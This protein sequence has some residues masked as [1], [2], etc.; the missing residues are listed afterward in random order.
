M[1]LHQ[2]LTDRL[3][4]AVEEQ[5]VLFTLFW[6][7]EANK[8][9][10]MAQV[11]NS[12]HSTRKL[13]ALESIAKN[14]FTKLRKV[15]LEILLLSGADTRQGYILDLAIEAKNREV[16]EIL[17]GWENGDREDLKVPL[18]LLALP[19]ADAGDV[20]DQ[21]L[22]EPP[23][24]ASLT[25]YNPLPDPASFPPAPTAAPPREPTPPTVN[26]VEAPAP[27]PPR[28]R[29]TPPSRTETK[30]PP[31]IPAPSEPTIPRPR[32]PSYPRTTTKSIERERSPSRSTRERRQRPDSPPPRLESTSRSRSKSRSSR[33][34]S[35]R[36]RPPPPILHLNSTNLV[37]INVARFPVGWNG[38]DLQ[39]MFGSIGVAS[40]VILCHST[41][42][43]TYAFL[44]VDRDEANRCIRL[45]E[46]SLQGD[47]R[48]R[49]NF[50][51]RQSQNFSRGPPLG[52][53]GSLSGSG[54]GG[55]GGDLSSRP[56]IPQRPTLSPPPPS[57]S[58]TSH[59]PP[60]YPPRPDSTLPPSPST[61]FTNGDSYRSLPPSSSSST[62]K[63]VMILNLPYHETDEARIV[64]N[65]LRYFDLIRLEE[66]NQAVA[67]FP[68]TTK[69]E[70]LYKLWDDYVVDG[71]RLKVVYAKE[72]LSAKEAIKDYFEGSATNG[73]GGGGSSRGTTTRSN[74][75]SLVRSRS[76]RSRSQRR[77][78]SP[79]RGGGDVE[80]DTRSSR[81]HKSSS[82]RSKRSN[83]TTRRSGSVD[84]N[85]SYGPSPPP[86][87]IATTVTAT[88]TTS[89]S[90]ARPSPMSRNGSRSSASKYKDSTFSS[91]GSSRR[92]RERSTRSRE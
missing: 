16:A 8:E 78:R 38:P 41:Y 91:S 66:R 23:N 69:G 21:T 4:V 30:P 44:D 85:T 88:T 70:H 68:E 52:E 57:R 33:P 50:A 84:S 72:G 27:A 76:E 34:N 17:K 82:K 37:R 12:R 45:L 80:D 3:V 26:P 49:C 24:A 42:W 13:S 31:S 22:P 53:R 83:T 65:K 59:Y 32:S 28:P 14:G 46:G 87:D 51:G 58:S 55:G 62:A 20:I 5:D 75:S 81:S 77:S 18:K 43:P 2:E 89:S 74:G 1:D 86:P 19:L 35:P 90:A 6:L 36:Y 92:H 11:I 48:I 61:T 40:K 15:L 54:G 79:P 29:D 7:N 60:R 73:G 71:K 63:N 39:G 10:D 9:Q 64:V 47:A 67:W 25:G 56:M